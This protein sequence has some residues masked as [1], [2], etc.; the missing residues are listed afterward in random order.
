MRRIGVEERRARLAVRHHLA[1][2]AGAADLAELAGDLVGLH[3]TDPAS[4][5]LAVRARAEGGSIADV[6]RVLYDE[7]RVLRM[8]GMRRTMF[9][10]P[11][12]LAAIVQAACTE[13]IAVT[14]RRRYA[15]L[16]EEGGI[17]DDGEAWL[18]D[19]A[20]AT[21]QALEARGQAFASELSGDV[22]R[23]REKVSYGEGKTWAGNI[24]MTTWVLVLLAA[25]GS[26]VRGRPRGQPANSQ[27]RRAAAARWP[28]SG[29]RT[30]APS[31]PAAGSP[32]TAPRPSAT[33]SGGRA[34]G[35]AGRVRRSP[36]SGPPR[37]AWTASRESR[38]RTISSR[39]RRRSPGWR[40]CLPS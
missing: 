35:S 27:C 25:H 10:L 21:L 26:I 14:Q 4:V 37:A 2:N 32:R 34:G 33:W 7:R 30:R 19:A 15:K 40:C 38:S 13:A 17:A 20:A 28:P 3:A 1:P 22:P 23:L 6:D 8:I 24:G 18:D 11:L 5:Y 12:E 39:I 36:P 9:V 16:I 29:P 31:S